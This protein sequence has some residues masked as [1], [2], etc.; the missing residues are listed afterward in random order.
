MASP[1]KS[2]Q[3]S[4]SEQA[5]M[6]VL[7]YSGVSGKSIAIGGQPGKSVRPLCKK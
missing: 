2:Y 5:G 7:G 6:V 1:G 3:D 4:I